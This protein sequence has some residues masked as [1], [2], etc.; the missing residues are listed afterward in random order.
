MVAGALIS[1]AF[2]VLE[3]GSEPL[4]E[5]QFW[6]RRIIKVLPDNIMIRL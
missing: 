3:I 4:F 6:D 1:S 5:I 2:I